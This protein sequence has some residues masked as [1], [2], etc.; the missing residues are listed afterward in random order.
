MTQKKFDHPLNDVFDI[1]GEYE[2]ESMTYEDPSMSMTEAE[3]AAG[4]E[5][6]PAEIPHPSQQPYQKDEED[7][8]TDKKI[9][10]VYDMALDAFRTQNDYLEVIE[11]RYA[12]RNAEVAAGYLKIALD[13]ANSKAKIKN[14]RSK[15]TQYI[16]FGN[17][18]NNNLMVTNREKILDMIADSKKNKE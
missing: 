18:T 15:T 4:G 12:A 17:V 13:A 7:K 9:D 10:E 2:D 5:S 16:P 14:D 8:E 6:L 3:G 1:D 11:P